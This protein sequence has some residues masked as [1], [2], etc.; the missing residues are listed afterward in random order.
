[1]KLDAKTL[2][3]IKKECR[4]QAHELMLQAYQIYDNIWYDRIKIDS[5]LLAH[6]KEVIKEI[7]LKMPNL[8]SHDPCRS[9]LDIISK[10]YGFETE[11]ELIEYLLAYK[12]RGPYED[13]LYEG[14]LENE[15]ATYGLPPETEPG[16][17]PQVDEVPF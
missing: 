8:L 3:A 15:L 5:A 17:G 10:R 1:M 12:P 7:N 16:A 11:S 9:P 14:L 2:R 6:G 13:R 4:E